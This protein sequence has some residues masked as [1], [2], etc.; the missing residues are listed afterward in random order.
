MIDIWSDPSEAE[1]EDVML[2]AIRWRK[3]MMSELPPHDH[4]M[5]FTGYV[6]KVLQSCSNNIIYER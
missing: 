4:L 2:R 5:I 3:T 1:V 6:L